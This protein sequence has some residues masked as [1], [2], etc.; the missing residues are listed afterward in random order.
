MFFESDL[1][2]HEIDRYTR[3]IIVP[4]VKVSGQIKLRNSRVLVVGCGGL[5]APVI[6][7]LGSCGIGELGVL[8]YDVV[9]LHNLQRQVIYRECD[10]GK[11]KSEVAGEFLKSLN[12]SI[13]INIHNIF[14]DINNV[15]EV[16]SGYDLIL[17]CCDN[18]RTRYMLADLCKRRGKDII[19][20]SVLKWEGQLYKITAGGPCYRCLF[21]DMKTMVQSCETS[22]VIGPVCGV[23]GSMQ[24][25]E[26]IKLLLGN[27]EPKLLIYNGTTN[28]LTNV[29]LRK[30]KNDCLICSG[31]D[32]AL[33]D[34]SEKATCLD[35]AADMYNSVP[36]ISWK[37]I[38]KN[39]DNYYIVDVRSPIQYEMF[40]AKSSVNIPLVALSEMINTLKSI[41]KPIVITCKRGITSQKA[42]QILKNHGIPSM[43]AD[44][45]ITKFK[46]CVKNF[47]E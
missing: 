39:Y 40:R 38:F 26:A 45:G 36:T 33:F 42:V 6:V 18:I 15:E 25:T 29:K 34:Y 32:E 1:Q 17:D 12:A 5:G 35:S 22:G 4:G 2:K 8:D 31:K 46:E 43:S 24:A 27:K 30:S 11:Y 13:K 3:Q 10:V 21:P 37:E 44:G 28:R 47:E 41:K 14:L 19:C 23:M 20:A 16:I 7:Y 9:E